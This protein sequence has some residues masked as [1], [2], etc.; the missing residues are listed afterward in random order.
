MKKVQPAS[1]SPSAVEEPQ[2]S[3]KVH[4]NGRGEVLRGIM[5]RVFALY[6]RQEAAVP[7]YGDITPPGRYGNLQSWDAFHRFYSN[8]VAG[9]EGGY[10][11]NDGNDAPANYGINQRA[12]PDVDVLALTQDQAEQMLYERYWLASGADQLPTALAAVHGDTAINLGVRAANELLAQSG[13]DP[14]TYLDLRDERY[15]AI[16]AANPDKTSYLSVWLRRNE[17]LRGLLNSG[18]DL[19]VDRPSSPERLPQRQISTWAAGDPDR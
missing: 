12:N 3:I 2:P 11:E 17:D 5:A 8:F 9:H 7:P 14:S 18:T 15:R 4:S 10:T 6:T 13:G 1:V 16:A 19:I